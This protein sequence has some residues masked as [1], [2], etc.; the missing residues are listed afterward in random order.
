MVRGGCA[1]HVSLAACRFLE[2]SCRMVVDTL[3]LIF[4]YK[5]GQPS[6]VA[7]GNRLVFVLSLQQPPS[8]GRR[9]RSC[10]WPTGS[11]W[12]ARVHELAAFFG[13]AASAKVGGRLPSSHRCLQKTPTV[14]TL[15]FFCPLV[16]AVL[17]S[18]FLLP[19]GVSVLDFLAAALVHEHQH[20]P[21]FAHFPA[22]L[23]HKQTAGLCVVR[24]SSN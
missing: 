19:S 9:S 21:I 11:D 18:P 24:S 12:A 6:I 15:R 23:E 3:H 8:R 22:L 17:H 1:R 5:T 13:C 16:H 10:R 7:A 2:S 14:P 4:V 20:A